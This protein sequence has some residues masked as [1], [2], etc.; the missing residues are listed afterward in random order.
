MT[1]ATRFSAAAG[2]A[3]NVKNPKRIRTSDGKRRMASSA[4]RTNKARLSVTLLGHLLDVRLHLVARHC[5]GHH[6]ADQ[7]SE[8]PSHIGRSLEEILLGQAEF[9]GNPNEAYV[10]LVG[11]RQR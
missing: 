1:S 4:Q 7:R 5:S 6:P 10:S 8:L 2:A 11:S 9:R 3:Q